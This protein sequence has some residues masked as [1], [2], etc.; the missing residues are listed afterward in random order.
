MIVKS[1]LI[2]SRAY[3]DTK[4]FIQD[5]GHILVIMKVALKNSIKNLI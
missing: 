1:N 5:N 3:Q 2:Y 4:L